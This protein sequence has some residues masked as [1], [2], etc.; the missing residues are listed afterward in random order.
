M[1]RI[2]PATN[3]NYVHHRNVPS[4]S[5]SNETKTKT[6][7]TYLNTTKLYI[8]QQSPQD[9]SSSQYP[10][11]PPPVPLRNPVN[12]NKKNSITIPNFNSS[13]S[14]KTIYR[15]PAITPTLNNSD[16]NCLEN[17]FSSL[18]IDNNDHSQETTNESTIRE[19]FGEKLSISYQ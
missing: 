12:S 3:N 10:P 4:P 1:P 2:M 14:E 9:V 17:K 5:L 8:A 7:T 15:S 16:D 18:A 6:N 19:Y 11:E 13:T